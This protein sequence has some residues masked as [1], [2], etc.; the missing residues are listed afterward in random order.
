M[1]ISGI[2]MILIALTAA[3]RGSGQATVKLMV[4][5]SDCAVEDVKLSDISVKLQNASG[6]CTI[7]YAFTA[8]CGTMP[9]ADVAF[10]LVLPGGKSLALQKTDANGKSKG[11]L[12][13]GAV[14]MTFD[15]CLQQLNNKTAKLTLTNDK[16]EQS[17]VGTAKITRQ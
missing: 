6:K 16:D 2:A 13:S 7:G 1:R 5:D 4:K 15:A 3:C 12:L 8:K 10:T 14:N 11:R 17:D 9:L